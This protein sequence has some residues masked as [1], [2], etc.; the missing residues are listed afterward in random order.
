[1]S[2]AKG[3]YPEWAPKCGPQGHTPWCRHQPSCRFMRHLVERTGRAIMR[4]LRRESFTSKL[5]PPQTWEQELEA[6]HDKFEL[7]T[8]P[9]TQAFREEHKRFWDAALPPL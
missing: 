9:V 4:E 3:K 1:M 2:Y 5:L 6:N 7:F 8:K